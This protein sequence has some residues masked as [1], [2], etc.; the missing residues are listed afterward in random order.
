[1]FR[2]L[3]LLQCSQ[4]EMP[5]A[6]PV[7]PEPKASAEAPVDGGRAASDSFLEGIGD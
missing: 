4:E 3:E 5:D 7:D 2:N 1:M 6:E